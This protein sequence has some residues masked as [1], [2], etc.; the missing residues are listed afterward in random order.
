[1]LST[2]FGEVWGARTVVWLALGAAAA[3]GARPRLLAVPA[4]ALVVAPALEGHS[5]TISPTALLIGLDVLHVLAMTVWLGGLVALIAVVPYATRALPESER[6]TLLAGVLGR[7]SPLALTA[8]LTLATTGTVAAISLLTK[9]SQLWDTGYG[10]ELLAKIA[11]LGA[12]AALGAVNRSR[13]LPRLRELG[14]T[15]QA[16]GTTGRLLRKTLRAEVLLATAVLGVSAVL[17]DGIPPVSAA[18]GPFSASERIGP[19]D[20]EVTIDPARAGANEMHVY[21]FVAKTGAPFTG[22]KWL[23][24]SAALPAKK[25]GP[26]PITLRR[27]GD[28]HFTADTLQLLPAGDWTLQIADRVS[29]FDE[30]TTTLEVNIK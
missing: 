28:G 25:I 1:V 11:L 17:V 19:L 5:A 3:A 2:R 8:V 13:V 9:L 24:A 15:G 18:S 7:F 22:T 4:A 23:T 21:L 29:D 20:L 26:L 27:S 14:A 12:L 10:R 6:S 16:P 30:Y